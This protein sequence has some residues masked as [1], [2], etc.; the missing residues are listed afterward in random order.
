MRFQS[1]VVITL[2]CCEAVIAS[3]RDMEFSTKFQSHMQRCSVFDLI[4]LVQT[5]NCSRVG[6]ILTSITGIIIRI[7]HFT[8]A[9][10]QKNSVMKASKSMCLYAQ[11]LV[12]GASGA[13]GDQ[14]TENT[15]LMA[16]YTKDIQNA[17]KVSYG[18]TC[19]NEKPTL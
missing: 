18:T 13:S 4:G 11:V 3:H 16:I 17:E 9:S 1:F 2:N 10:V 8:F 19:R 15:E 6:Q 7:T 5:Q 12:N 14:D